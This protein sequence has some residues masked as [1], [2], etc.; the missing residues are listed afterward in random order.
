MSV[1]GLSPRRVQRFQAEAE[2][3]G[4]PVV[5]YAGSRRA[6]PAATEALARPQ[7]GGNFIAA[8]SY[9]D[10]TT[11]AIGTTTAICGKEA[12]AF[13]HPLQFIGASTYGANDGNS[14]VHRQGRPPSGPSSWPPSGPSSARS[15]R[16]GWPASAPT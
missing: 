13:G 1:S 14:L 6:A 3:D 10:L 7:A 9:G 8:L 12:V 5:A 4:L 2:A 16:T 11:A 15:I